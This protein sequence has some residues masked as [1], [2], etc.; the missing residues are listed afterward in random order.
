LSAVSLQALTNMMFFYIVLLA[1]AISTIHAENFPRKTSLF[2]S[3]QNKNGKGSN[4]ERIMQIMQLRGGSS[5]M[6]W[7]YFVA[8]GVC[9]ACSHGI[10]TPIGR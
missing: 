10:T 9:A 5:D 3:K 7:R 4:D 2:F 1:L 8:G 6:D